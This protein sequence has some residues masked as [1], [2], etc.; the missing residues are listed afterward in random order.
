MV[1]DKRKKNV[2]KAVKKSKNVKRE[3]KK[4]KRIGFDPTDRDIL[5][6]LNK[7]KLSAT[8]SKI[9]RTINVH[10]STVK[11][12]VQRLNKMNLLTLK[13]RGNR[14]LVKTDK[15]DKAAIKRRLKKV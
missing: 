14:I 10:P 12:R 2:K 7:A 4:R 6:V 8:P 3:V 11:N 15:A 13:S 1:K 9:A 5:R